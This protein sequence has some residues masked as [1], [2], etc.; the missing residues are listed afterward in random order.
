MALTEAVSKSDAAL[1]KNLATIDLCN[2]GERSFAHY[3]RIQTNWLV[4]IMKTA[5]A[6][7][8]EM[9]AKRV[10]CVNDKDPQLLQDM[11]RHDDSG[12]NNVCSKRRMI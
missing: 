8:C 7:L 2:S 10:K 1:E 11:V 5:P 12:H 6:D 9:A 3:L 4:F